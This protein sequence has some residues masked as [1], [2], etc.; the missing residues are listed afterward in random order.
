MAATPSVRPP[1]GRRFAVTGALAVV[2]GGSPAQA[3]DE[4]LSDYRPARF[5]GKDTLLSRQDRHLVARFSY[6]VTPDL[7]REVRRAGGARAWFE[8]Q[9]RP[10]TVKD[11]KAGRLQS[12]WPSLRRSPRELWQR[13]INDIEG[14]WEVMDDYARWS[15][16]RRMTSRRQV[17][18]V[19]AEFWENHLHVPA[20]GDAQFTHRVDYGMEI[21]KHA[22]GR[23]DEMLLATTTHPAMLIYLDAVESTK[24]HPNENLGRELLELHTVGRGNYN[25]KDVKNS[26]RILTGWSVDMW[27][28]W[29]PQYHEDEH[30]LGTVKVKGFKDKNRKANGKALTAAYLRYLAR[31]PD[32]AEHLAAKLCE[33]FIGDKAS[34][35]LVKRLARVYL[36]NDTAIVP[37]LRALVESKQFRRSVDD[38]VRDPAEDLVATYRALRIKVRRPP[39]GEEA[40]GAS[41]IAA[42][43]WQAGSI[44]LV[45]FSWA[46]PDGQ[47]LDNESWSSPGRLMGSMDVHWQL[48][49]GHWPETAVRYRKPM[50]WMPGPA[51]RFDELVDHLSQQ[52]LHRHSDARLLKACSR[53][54]DV[55]PKDYVTED[56]EL[57]EWKFG[58][59]LATILD[60]PDH[61]T[62]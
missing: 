34:R 12:W 13:Q 42:M 15:M 25:E 33:K 19:M 41:A 39:R 32:T 5:K 40:Y 60:S 23:F 6:G 8:R 61:Y 50:A 26:A 3:A 7:A 57:I 37:V 30:Y 55:R 17:L 53:A 54:T 35:S 44:G 22:L 10:R 11:G 18:E 56:H 51:V 52:L 28:T 38:K 2:A 36:A 58:R 62:R 49:H 46:S 4:D 16:M 1:V 31:H 43:V 14:G 59:L 48:A 21:R 24:D 9:L 45:P 20:L 29:R 27:K 47:P